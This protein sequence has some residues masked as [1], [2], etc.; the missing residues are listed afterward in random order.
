MAGS[1]PVC[2]GAGAVSATSVSAYDPAFDFVI[3]VGTNRPIGMH[4][5]ISHTLCALDTHQAGIAPRHL[6]RC[7]H[8]RSAQ[9]EHLGSGGIAPSDRAE[10]GS[11]ALIRRPGGSS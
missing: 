7:R 6:F 8:A 5:C 2:L 10:P 9:F 11:L 3:C 1:P 4:F